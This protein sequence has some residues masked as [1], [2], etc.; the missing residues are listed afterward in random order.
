V[1]INAAFVLAYVARYV[2][3]IGGNVEAVNYVSL[4][5]FLPVQLALTFILIFVYRM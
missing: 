5:A 1:L 3:E 2:L 4:D